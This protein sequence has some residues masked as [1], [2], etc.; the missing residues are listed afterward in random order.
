ML[1]LYLSGAIGQNGF[2]NY[3]VYCHSLFFHFEA[4]MIY[5]FDGG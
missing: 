4:V 2:F 3:Y 1:S 5:G